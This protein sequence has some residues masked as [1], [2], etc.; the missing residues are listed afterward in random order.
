MATGVTRI[1]ADPPE[2]SFVYEDD[3]DAELL[4]S[5]TPNHHG[6]TV[7]ESDDGRVACGV[8]ACGVYKDGSRHSHTTS[9]SS[10][11]KAS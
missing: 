8:W 6:V 10:F 2:G 9:C 7:M 5:G 11:W 1:D 3:V 4:I